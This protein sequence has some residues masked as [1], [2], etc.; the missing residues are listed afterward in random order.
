MTE[1]GGPYPGVVDL[2][3]EVGYL[4]YLAVV[5]S[6]LL[7][8][9][10]G[11]VADHER[12][13]VLWELEGARAVQ[14][15]AAHPAPRPVVGGTAAARRVRRV[16]RPDQPGRVRLTSTDTGTSPTGHGHIINRAWAMGISPTG[17]GHITNRARAQ[18]GTGTSP[19]GHGHIT[20]WTRAHH[21]RGTGTPQTGA[22]EMRKRRN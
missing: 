12:L 7:Q 10:P 2:A 16:Q 15:D 18:P 1:R 17:H 22:Y 9:F 21:Q 5:V 8:H 14:T 3:A 4:V 6:A 19:T 13:G 11:R 20:N